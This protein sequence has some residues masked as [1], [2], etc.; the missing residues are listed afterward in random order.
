MQEV[1]LVFSPEGKVMLWHEPLGRSSGWI[2][3]SS[4]LWDFLWQNRESIGGIAHTHPWI[5]KAWP[6][7]T[8]KTTFAAIEAG[9]G[10]R[11]LWSIISDDDIRFLVF[12]PVTSEYVEAT[13]TFSET[14]EWKTL[15]EEMR[16][17]S[18]GA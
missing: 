14:E 6:S 12:N 11:L 13:S 17:K 10:K 15:V 5:G 2:P 4:S 8:D 16:K 7:K 3:D 9:L 1:A 18:K